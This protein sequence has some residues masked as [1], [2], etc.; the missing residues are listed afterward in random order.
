MTTIDK[1][2]YLASVKKKSRK[3]PY[4]W[5]TV[6]R[7]MVVEIPTNLRS[8]TPE[9]LGKDMEVNPQNA[10]SVSP[11]NAPQKPFLLRSS[12]YILEPHLLSLPVAS[13]QSSRGSE[14]TK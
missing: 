7:E 3:I 8:V 4:F 13:W 12:V 9:F 2:E 1:K 11:V 5:L 10:L 14:C 6:E